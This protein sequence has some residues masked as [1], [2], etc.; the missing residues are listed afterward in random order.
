M[1]RG[2]PVT[3]V[4][5]G[6][7]GRRG[8][9]FDLD[10][11]LIDSAVGIAE[12][13]N[14]TLEDLGCAREPEALIRGWI[15][16]GARELLAMALAH[17]GRQA[18]GAEDFEA[19]FARLMH[20]YEESLP[21][22]ARAFPGA[23]ATLRALRDAGIGTALCTNKP[24]RFIAPLLEALD[25][26]DAFDA[27]VGGDT[28]PVRKPEPAPLLHCAAALDAEPA[29]CLMVGDSRTDADAAHAAGMPLVLVRF[30]YARGFD[31]DTAGALR[32]VDALPEV[33]G[34]VS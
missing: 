5:E 6:S 24:Q 27:I 10:G 26:S 13:L 16:D 23:G 7:A 8:V 18:P 25:W 17:A 1:P 9:L 12:A 19:A 4:R 21:L 28:L 3:R 29:R 2:G 33:M 15:G 11:T 32:V 34:L 30:G 31:V 14:R 20:H 22:Q